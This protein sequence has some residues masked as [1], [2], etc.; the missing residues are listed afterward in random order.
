MM[1]ANL[2]SVNETFISNLSQ[3]VVASWILSEG[4]KNNILG[5]YRSVGVSCHSKVENNKLVF[6]IVMV[7]N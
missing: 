7:F 6:K 2:L 1:V 5:N 4:H 3:S